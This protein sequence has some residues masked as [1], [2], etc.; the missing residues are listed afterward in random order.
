M[1]A[2]PDNAPLR[3]E[4]A[5]LSDAELAARLRDLRPGQHNTT[6]LT[7]R[8]RLVRAI[9]IA[10]YSSTHAPEP[11]PAVRPLVLGMRWPRE[12]LHRR[13]RA[14][15]T[16]RLEQGLI[17]EVA[18]L[19]ERGVTWEKLDYL[20]L[21]YRFIANHLRGATSRNDMTQQLASAISQF[22]KRQETWFR[23][24]ER[25]GTAI[26]WIDRAD[27]AAALALVNAAWVRT[28]RAGSA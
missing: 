10:E 28:G 26:H 22:A 14:R 7:D 17:D 20:G 4:L 5:S 8:A 12:E 9:E 19:H 24:M 25:Q 1:V 23:R 2:V 11:T 6:D 27:T 13:I 15:L 18:S 16:A 21:E 3:A